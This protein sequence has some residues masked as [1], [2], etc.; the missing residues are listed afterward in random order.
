MYGFRAWSTH[1]TRLETRLPD[2]RDDGEELEDSVKENVSMVLVVSYR[3]GLR[4]YLRCRGATLN[5]YTP[6][7]L[8]GS[9]RGCPS[10]GWDVSPVTTFLSSETNH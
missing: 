8:A 10:G 1:F 9:L 2:G 3:I 4:T 6:S 7:L 5:I